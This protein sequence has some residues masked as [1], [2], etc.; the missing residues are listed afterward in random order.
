MRHCNMFLFSAAENNSNEVC[1]E[2]DA[3][4]YV[5]LLLQRAFYG[6]FLSF[7]CCFLYKFCIGTWTSYGLNSYWPFYFY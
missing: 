7:I 4:V 6:C 3:F 5:I 2:K 1:R